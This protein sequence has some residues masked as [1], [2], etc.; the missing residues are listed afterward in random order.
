MKLKSL[1]PFPLLIASFTLVACQ[2]KGYYT[3]ENGTSVFHEQKAKYQLNVD[4]SEYKDYCK[5]LP[6]TNKYLEGTIISF[7]LVF[8]DRVEFYPYLNSKM[9]EPKEV[10]DGFRE[11]GF[12]MPSEGSTLEIGGIYYG[13]ETSI[14]EVVP[15]LN[16]L[17]QDDIKGVQVIIGSFKTGLEPE[18][19]DLGSDKYSEDARDIEYNYSILSLKQLKKTS[20]YAYDEAPTYK[21]VFTLNNKGKV[22]YSFDCRRIKCAEFETNPYYYYFL[23]DAQLPK[24]QHPSNI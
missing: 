13:K 24:I 14:K 16:D 3:E 4:V 8:T 5:D 11:Y 23:K 21:V 18:D 12:R 2:Q 17:K 20:S 19:Y 6:E 22:E 9:L 15:A 7:K 10:K 1:L